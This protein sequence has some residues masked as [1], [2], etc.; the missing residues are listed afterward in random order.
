M[1]SDSEAPA[2]DVERCLDSLASALRTWG[3]LAFDTADRKSA[4][5]S[6]AFEAWARHVLLA[7]PAPGDGVGPAKGQARDWVGLEEFI[8][9][10]RGEE[11]AY[12][13]ETLEDLRAVVWIFVE[14]FGRSMSADNKSDARVTVQLERLR[15]AA[16]A[17]DTAGLKS[18]ALRSASVIEGAITV[19]EAR[20]QSH[21]EKLSGRLEEMATQLVESRRKGSFDPL[22]GVYNRASL[23]EQLETIVNLGRFVGDAAIV[24]M[25]DIDHF[26]W[27]ND[28]YGHQS[29]DDL[30]R[31]V[32]RGLNQALRRQADFVAR[33]G[34]DEFVAIV[35]GGTEQHLHE[36]GERILHAIRDVEVK[37]DDG[38]VRVSCSVG[39]ARLRQSDGAA[40][41]LKR[42]D[43]AMYQAKQAGRDRLVVA[44]KENEEDLGG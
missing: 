42:A 21:I 32:G 3:R 13:V 20:Y 26:K 8:K 11:S 27:V 38:P 36:M 19:R 31:R 30:L 35:H 16:K 18:E 14:A 33:Y 17:D 1:S 9:A 5:T 15:D 40:S 2:V 28:K 7:T 25:I 41:W 39:A 12:V 34:G 37:T 43:D 24:F 4:E 10:E 22:T 44:G 6:E 29:G 23:D